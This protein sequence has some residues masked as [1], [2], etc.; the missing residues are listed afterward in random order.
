M[1]T[2][3]ELVFAK[4]DTQI[5]RELTVLVDDVF[6]EEAIGRYNGQAP[7]IDSICKIQSCNTNIGEFIQTKITARDDYDF[8]VKK[9]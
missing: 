5:G 8:I 2:Q 6:E 1:Q 4:M 3:Q 9:M 7:H